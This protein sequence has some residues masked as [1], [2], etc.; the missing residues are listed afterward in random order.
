MVSVKAWKNG[1]AGEPAFPADFEV[2]RKAVLQI[3]E[4]RTNRNKYYALELHKTDKPAGGD[5]PACR[6]F[7]HYGRTDDLETN[8]DSG[9]KECRYFG[10]LAEAQAAYDAIYR[11]KTG[12]AKGYKEVSLAA[13]K[14]GSMKARGTGSGVIDAKTLDMLARAKAE[15]RKSTRLNSSHGYISYAVF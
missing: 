2:V 3:T 12:S 1:E 7:T 11:Q 10:S 6:L 13:S 9:Q 4:I 15:D 8:P 5:K 14:I